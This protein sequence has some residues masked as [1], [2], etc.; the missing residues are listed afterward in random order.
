MQISMKK[1]Q[2]TK[3]IIS[4]IYSYGLKIKFAKISLK[5]P[6]QL[7]SFLTFK[8]NHTENTF[9]SC[10]MLVEKNLQQEPHVSET[11]TRLGSSWESKS[12]SSALPPPKSRESNS[13]SFNSYLLFFI[14]LFKDSFNLQN[15]SLIKSVSWEFVEKS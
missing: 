5:L 3:S 10:F 8:M 12:A 11:L 4:L 14:Q 6:E 15:S 1:F 7:I 2:M 13:F 9:L